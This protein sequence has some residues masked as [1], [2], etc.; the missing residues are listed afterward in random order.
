MEERLTLFYWPQRVEL[1]PG[2]MGN[3]RRNLESQNKRNQSSNYVLIL[4]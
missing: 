4:R 1:G 3:V 2:S